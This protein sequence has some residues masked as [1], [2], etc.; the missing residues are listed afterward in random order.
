MLADVAVSKGALAV[1]KEKNDGAEMDG[2]QEGGELTANVGET[3]T[4]G[5]G[6]GSGNAPTPEE[7]ALKTVGDESG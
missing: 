6:V 7:E 5:K 2:E 4:A 1:S 3:D